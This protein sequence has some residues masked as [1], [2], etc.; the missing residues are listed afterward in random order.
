MRSRNEALTIFDEK[1]MDFHHRVRRAYREFA[2]IC[3]SRC[4]IVDASRPF[5][6]VI[7]SVFK[8]YETL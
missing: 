7:E 4:V 3:D 5:K 1:P 6:V 8:I 2:D